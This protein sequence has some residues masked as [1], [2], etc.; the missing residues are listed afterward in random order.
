VHHEQSK[1]N[2]ALFDIGDVI[3]TSKAVVIDLPAG[4]LRRVAGRRLF[5]AWTAAS[6]RGSPVWMRSSRIHHGR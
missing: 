2:D 5:A 3:D 4:G 1:Q 6:K